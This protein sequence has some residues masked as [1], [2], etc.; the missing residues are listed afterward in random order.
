M[1]SLFLSDLEDFIARAFDGLIHVQ[2]LAHQ[3]L[4]DPD[5][6]IG[7]YFK[8]YV[9][10]YADDTVIFAESAEQLQAALNGLFIYCNTWKLTV[11]PTKTKIVVFSQSKVKGNPVFTYNNQ[12][13]NVEQDFNY[14]GILLTIKGNFIRR[15]QNL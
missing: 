8:L 3:T 4:D 13:I 1:F 15:E 6:V 5:D 10:L 11:N 2:D 14:F 9:L 7:T 12:I